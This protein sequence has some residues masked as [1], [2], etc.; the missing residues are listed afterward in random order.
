MC[1]WGIRNGRSP[2]SIS[3]P[4]LGCRIIYIT[5]DPSLSTAQEQNTDAIPPGQNT[6][7]TSLSRFPLPLDGL[8]SKPII[9]LG[10]YYIYHWLSVDQLFPQSRPPTHPD[11][12]LA[13]FIHDLS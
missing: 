7:T 5:L 10:R 6:Y 8:H 11:G 9:V 4:H 1:E 2:V 3:L 13:S 12:A